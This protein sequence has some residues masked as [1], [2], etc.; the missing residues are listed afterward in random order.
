MNLVITTP[1]GRVNNAPI[2]IKNMGEAMEGF[3]GTLNWSIVFDKKEHTSLF[4]QT[5]IRHRPRVGGP[6]T[7]LS[8]IGKRKGLLT[9]N[10]VVNYD[11]DVLEHNGWLEPKEGEP[12]YWGLLN[13]DNAFDTGFFR[14]LSDSIAAER[15]DPPPV[16]VVSMHRWFYQFSIQNT[17][18][19][20]KE[21]MVR[22]KVGLEQL[23]IRLD[24]LRNYRLNSDAVADGVL[25]EQLLA[26]FGDEVLYLPN[27]HIHFNRWGQ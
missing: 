22:C 27:L 5:D 7:W 26:D 2:I 6:V 17:L 19:A 20:S 23:Y 18:A 8:V 12:T 13:D 16:V 1:F 14:R 21:N 25:A 10:A 9:G 24:V 3:Q 15:K 11:W 4:T